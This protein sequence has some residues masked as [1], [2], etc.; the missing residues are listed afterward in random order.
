MKSP[1]TT[2]ESHWGQVCGKVSLNGGPERPSYEAGKPG[3]P[4]R[5][6]DVSDARALVYL[7]KQ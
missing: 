4:W 2:K 6:Q 7:P 3:L 5:P 1:S